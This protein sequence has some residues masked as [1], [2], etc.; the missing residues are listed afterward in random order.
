MMPNGR[1]KQ[2]RSAKPFLP[3]SQAINFPLYIQNMKWQAINDPFDQEMPPSLW[4]SRINW[5]KKG[6]TLSDL[7]QELVLPQRGGLA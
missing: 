2:K 3:K 4:K 7:C 5:I 6:A 1:E